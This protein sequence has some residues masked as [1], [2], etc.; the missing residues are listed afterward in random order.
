M[1]L[2]IIPDHELNAEAARRAKE[3]DREYTERRHQEYV[4]RQRRYMDEDLA[5]CARIGITYEQYEEAIG[6]YTSVHDERW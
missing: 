4:A 2:T 3:R 1:D 6:H 5:E